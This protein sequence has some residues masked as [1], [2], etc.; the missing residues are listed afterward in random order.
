MNS[1]VLPVVPVDMSSGHEGYI[2]LR[3]GQKLWTRHI[4]HD[5]EIHRVQL[6]FGSYHD[7]DKGG[8]V[9]VGHRPHPHDIVKFDPAMKWLQAI[10]SLIPTEIRL[11]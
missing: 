6:D 11:C 10:K 1:P 4:I 3:N 7:V 8:F 2:E 5:G 9:E